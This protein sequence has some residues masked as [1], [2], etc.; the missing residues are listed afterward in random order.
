[1]DELSFQLKD[2]GA[3]ALVT[4]KPLLQNALKAAKAAGIPEARVILL[5]AQHDVDPGLK[6]FTSVRN[7]DSA[8]RFRRAKAK[9]GDL[10]FLVYSSGTTGLPKGVMLSHRNIC[11]N[12]LQSTAVDGKEL[13]WNGLEDGKGD[14]VLG[15]LPFFHVYGC[16]G[17]PRFRARV[18]R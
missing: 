17:L 2:A 16:S 3:R 1:M 8:A 4:V 10:A 14:R 18:V 7:M 15:F 9:P 11:V 13:T 12:I 6:H 5:G